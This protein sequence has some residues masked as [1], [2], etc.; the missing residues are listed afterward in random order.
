MAIANRPL[1]YAVLL[2][3]SLTSFAVRSAAAQAGVI[4]G[5]VRDT[6]GG[7]PLEAARVR[8]IIESFPLVRSASVFD[9]YTGPPVPT[10]RK[11]LAFSVSYQSPDHTLTD[12]EV[13]KQ[14]ER[15][16]ARLRQELGAELRA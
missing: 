6:S 3:G 16:V 12:A 15:N 7:T 9:V 1:L 2:L 13:A 5:T 11:S 10:G 4:T 14:R 8:E